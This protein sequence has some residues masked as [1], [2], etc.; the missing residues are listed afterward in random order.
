MKS[1][2]I[3]DNVTYPE[4]EPMDSIIYFAQWAYTK[5]GDK[6]HLKVIEKLKNSN[7]KIGLGFSGD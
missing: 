7:A 1:T 2:R 5:T 3:N 4:S 6:S